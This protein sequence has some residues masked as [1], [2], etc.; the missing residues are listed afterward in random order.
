M[1]PVPAVE[2]LMC[3]QQ[4]L[5][6]A[7]NELFREFLEY[8]KSKCNYVKINRNSPPPLNP[9]ISLNQGGLFL[10]TNLMIFNFLKIIREYP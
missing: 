1:K 8:K 7:N 4:S 6:K 2:E 9:E 10:M 3:N 5:W